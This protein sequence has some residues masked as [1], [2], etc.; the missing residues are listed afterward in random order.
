MYK[1]NAITSVYVYF[2]VVFVVLLLEYLH[3]FL[4]VFSIY[5]FLILSWN[6]LLNKNIKKQDMNV[7]WR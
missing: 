1:S 6:F 7:E 2:V 4:L 5:L 3:L